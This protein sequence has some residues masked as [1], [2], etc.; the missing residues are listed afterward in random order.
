MSGSASP[1]S[2]V[3]PAVSLPVSTVNS[4]KTAATLTQQLQQLQLQYQQSIQNKQSLSLEQL[5]RSYLH[6]LAPILSIS[7]SDDA[8]N[9][10]SALPQSSSSLVEVLVAGLKYR[11]TKGAAS[12]V[13]LHLHALLLLPRIGPAYSKLLAKKKIVVE[14][15]ATMKVRKQAA[16]T[17]RRHC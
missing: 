11:E 2:G 9:V 15:V 7:S 12:I 14:I 13:I 5:Y 4:P 6:C 1:S 10:T 3:S 16:E 17:Q 8:P